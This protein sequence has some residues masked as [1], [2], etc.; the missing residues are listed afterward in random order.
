MPDITNQRLVSASPTVSL[1]L[2]R[3]IDLDQLINLVKELVDEQ[4]CPSCGLNGWDLH[5]S[6]D[7]VIRYDRFTEKFNDV[8]SGVDVLAGGGFRGVG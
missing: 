7:P 1:K 8:L 6:I 4:G 3:Q 2:R 5:V